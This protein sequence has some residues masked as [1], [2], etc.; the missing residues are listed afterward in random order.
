MTNHDEAIAAIINEDDARDPTVSQTATSNQY[1][2]Y[3]QPT[4]SRELKPNCDYLR[5]LN[6]ENDVVKKDWLEEIPGR[7]VA[8]LS[9]D[10][11]TIKGNV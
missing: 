5:N 8:G 4:K 1:S 7:S 2:A 9:I 6:V 10:G 3:T 11:S